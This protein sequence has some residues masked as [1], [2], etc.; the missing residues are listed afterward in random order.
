VTQAPG[1]S[2]QGEDLDSGGVAAAHYRGVGTPRAACHRQRS[3][4][5]VLAPPCLCHCKQRTFITSVA[6]VIQLLLIMLS[7]IVT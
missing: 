4:A 5:V 3:E 6:N 2:L 1:A 7:F